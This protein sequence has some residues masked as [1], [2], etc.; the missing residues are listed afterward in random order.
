MIIPIKNILFEEMLTAGG[1]IYSLLEGNGLDDEEDTR[2][3]HKGYELY[4]TVKMDYE[5]LHNAEVE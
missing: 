1:S 5:Y 3:I 2:M 4:D